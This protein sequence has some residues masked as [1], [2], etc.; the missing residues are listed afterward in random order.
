MTTAEIAHD[1]IPPE[2]LQGIQDAAMTVAFTFRLDTQGIDFK[3]PA[4]FAAPNTIGPQSGH[5]VV[6]QVHSQ[7]SPVFAAVVDGISIDADS[8]T[9]VLQGQ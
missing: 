5:G 7:E 9:T 3:L 8:L 1:S 4:Q 6:L 2:I